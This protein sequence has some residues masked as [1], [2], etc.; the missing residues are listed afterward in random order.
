MQEES[1]APDTV[2]A[3][4][5]R[6]I[7]EAWRAGGAS[8]ELAYTAT[9][10]VRDMAAVNAVTFM[11][12][13]IGA[14]Q[15]DLGAKI[16][17]QARRIDAVQADLGAKIEAQAAR[18]D[19]VQADL[20]AKIEVQAAKTDALRADLGAR[21]EAQGTVLAAHTNSLRWMMGIL[22]AVFAAL[23]VLLAQAIREDFSLA[24]TAAARQPAANETPAAAEPSGESP[25]MPRGFAPVAPEPR[26]ASGPR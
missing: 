15:A 26:T 19:A 1:S 10:K 18:I 6:P 20:G 16:E 23:V 25:G 3:T 11:G 21:I 5:D 22:I 12:A 24:V 8:E 9:Q 13:R 2:M 14:V 17:A 4:D 7:F